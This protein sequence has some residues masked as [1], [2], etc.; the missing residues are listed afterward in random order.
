MYYVSEV[1]VSSRD[2]LERGL[3][4]HV[5][6]TTTMDQEISFEPQ[7]AT[8]SKKHTLSR[9]PKGHSTTFVTPEIGEKGYVR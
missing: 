7:T 4:L 9:E 1:E 3:P 5:K 8:F 2:Q 6:E